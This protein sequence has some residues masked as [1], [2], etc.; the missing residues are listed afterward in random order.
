MCKWAQHK[1]V[2]ERAQLPVCEVQRFAFRR[3]FRLFARRRLP[4]CQCNGPSTVTA[5]ASEEPQGKRALRGAVLFLLPR[6]RLRTTQVF[7]LVSK[8][9]APAV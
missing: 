5:E 9:S 7:E 2:S 8:R 3:P 1:S 6:S 4:L